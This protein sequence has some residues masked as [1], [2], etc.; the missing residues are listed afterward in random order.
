MLRVALAVSVLGVACGSSDKVVLSE[1]TVG[2][3]LTRACTTDGD[4]GDAGA[5]VVYELATEPQMLC[6]VPTEICND[7]QCSNEGQCLV[8]ITE[9]ERVFCAGHREPR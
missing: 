4:C 8:L 9:P 6:T 5:C 2:P 3:S 7:V 1:L